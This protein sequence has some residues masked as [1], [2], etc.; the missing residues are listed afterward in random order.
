MKP[1]PSLLS[2]RF[3]IAVIFAVGLFILLGVGRM[4]VEQIPDL[5]P[6]ILPIIGYQASETAVKIKNGSG[7]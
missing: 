4:T 2:S 5:W 7:K 6:L 3:I 1:S